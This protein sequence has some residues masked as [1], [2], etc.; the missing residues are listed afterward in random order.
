MRSTSVLLGLLT[1]LL[2]GC[3]PTTTL[4]PIPTATQTSTQVP[5]ATIVWFPATETPSPMPTQ[6]PSPTIELRPGVGEILYSEDF[7]SPAN[8]TL[9]ETASDRI[10][11]GGNELTLAL[12]RPSGY[13]DS[14]L[15]GALFSNFYAELTVNTNLC[16]STDEYG[17]LIRYQSQSNHYRYS[18]SCDGQVRLDRIYSGIAS[19]P[20]DWMISA[21]VPSAAPST[22]R[23]GV[24]AV[25]QEL[26]FFIN[27]QYQFSIN[28]SAI[29]SGTMGVFVRSGGETAVTVSFSDL[30]IYQ[31]EQ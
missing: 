6:I 26:R 11:V 21:A 31:I 27:D 1:I 24:W 7:N 14:I 23:L 3:F 10:I 18:L 16:S 19:S 20:Q 9:L 4:T 8:W 22:S 15:E 17:M 28:D 12:G 30:Q 2:S 5:T 25:G 29:P 13:I